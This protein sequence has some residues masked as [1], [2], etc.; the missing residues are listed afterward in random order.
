MEEPAP[1][2]RSERAAWYA[3]EGGGAV[4][5]LVVST[6]ESLEILNH[7]EIVGSEY[8][9]FLRGAMTSVLASA[10]FRT[11]IENTP[12][13]EVCVLHILRGGLCFALREALHDALGLVRHGSAF[14]SSQRRRDADGGWTVCE[15]LY[16]KIDVANGAVVLVGDVVATGTTLDHALTVLA[17]DLKARGR[18]LRKLIVFTIGC[19]RL[20]EILVEHDVTLR[21]AFPDYEGTTAVYLEGRFTLV[22]E[23]TEL[24]IALPGT[25]LIR[26]SALL[27][28]EFAASQRENVA[29]PL[30]RCVIYDA[31]SRAFDVPTYVEDVLGYW[32]GTR[33]LA[34][35]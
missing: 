2:S 18:S 23:K 16:R 9:S 27:S 30:E 17:Q 3:L 12:E 20:D 19:G 22:E 34:V 32:R 15:D 8:T 10:P 7:P 31:G 4:E 29:F 28:P 11:R 5:R 6:P 14:L 25:D 21:A 24:R 1:V 26:R 13:P 33:R 35:P